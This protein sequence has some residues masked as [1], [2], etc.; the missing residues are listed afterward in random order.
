[1]VGDEGIVLGFPFI[2]FTGICAAIMAV[3]HKSMC[4]TATDDGT[5]W[6]E[7]IESFASTAGTSG[8]PVGVMSW[9]ESTVESTK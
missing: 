4:C 9:A 2:P 8:R 1:L 7:F 5:R 3:L 6:M